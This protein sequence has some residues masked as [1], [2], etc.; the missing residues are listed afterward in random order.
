MNFIAGN[1]GP[2]RIN[3]NNFSDPAVFMNSLD[4]A[5]MSLYSP[6]CGS[7]FLSSLKGFPNRHHQHICSAFVVLKPAEALHPTHLMLRKRCHSFMFCL[8]TPCFTHLSTSLAQCSFSPL[9]RLCST[10]LL[11]SGNRYS[12]SSSSVGEGWSF[13]LVCERIIG[14][15]CILGIVLGVGEV[16]VTYFADAVGSA[17]HKHRSYVLEPVSAKIR[18]SRLTNASVVRPGCHVGVKTVICLF[19]KIF[20]YVVQRGDCHLWRRR[21]NVWSVVKTKFKLSHFTCL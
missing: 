9:F 2:Q 16:S 12:L 1:W 11:S 13:S 20:K 7:F 5:L 14:A 8:I 17:E 4:T 15:T 6:L 18:S 21:Q 3:A 10:G 19:K